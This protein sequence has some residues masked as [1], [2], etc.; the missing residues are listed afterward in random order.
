MGYVSQ[1]LWAIA[2]PR[3]KLDA[4]LTHCKLAH[5]PEV[6]AA[7]NDS[8]LMR[9]TYGGKAVI[10]VHESCKWY[11]SY[12]EVQAFMALFRFADEHSEQYELDGIFL[13]SGEEEPDLTTRQFGQEPY[14]LGSI[15]ISVE[16]NIEPGQPFNV[17]PAEG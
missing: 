4:F 17:P 13:R 6:S 14:D 8:S 7:L 3:E 12:P 16:M 9:G 10:Y 15:H 11:E 5:G 1:V 2:G